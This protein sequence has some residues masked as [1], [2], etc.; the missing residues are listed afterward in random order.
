MILA[1][2]KDNHKS[3]DGFEIGPDQTLDCG[4]SSG[5][6]LNPGFII[7]PNPVGFMRAGFGGFMGFMWVL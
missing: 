7:K 3:L 2:Y 6:A 1:G 5:F 4:V